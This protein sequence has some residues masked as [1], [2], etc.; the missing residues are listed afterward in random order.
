MKR[1]HVLPFGAEPVARGVRFRL[2]APSATTV[3]CAI[4]GSAPDALPM[5]PESGGWFALT[6]D[7]ARA[8]S[9]YRYLVDGMAVPDPA[10]RCQP[11]DV[12]GV[13]EVIDPE[14]YEWHDEAW[15]GRD[16]EEIVLYELH[17]GSFTATGDF[18]GVMRRLDHLVRL[19]V[20]AIE[21]MPVADFPGRRNWGY[22]GVL[23][24]APESRYGRPEDLKRLIEACHERGL[25]ILLDVV[26][27]HFGPD[28]NYLHAYA[29]DFFTKRHVTPWGDAINFDGPASRPVR[30][31]YIHNALY[32]LEEF[33]FDGLRFDAV[34]A[35]HDDSAPDILTEIAQTIR[36]RFTGSRPTHLI[37]ENDDN[38]PRYL[39]RDGAEPRLYTAQWDDDIH[40]ALHVL[41]TGET[42][43]YYEDYAECPADK[44]GRA[45]AEGFAYQGEA[46]AH[47]GGKKRG[48]PSAQLPPTAFISFLQNHDQVGNDAFG[49]RIIRQASPDAVHAAAAISLLSPH[50]P[51][52]FMGEEWGADQTFCF[53]C[54]FTGDLA[55]AVR[56]GRRREFAKSAG[57]KDPA[58]RERIPD[59][60]ADATFASSILDWSALDDPAHA[61]WLERYR[62]LIALR[63]REIAPRLRRIGGHAGRWRVIEEGALHVIWRL[64]DG[65]L[66]TLVAN[67]CERAVVVPETSAA[68]RRLYATAAQV[69]P[70]TAPPRSATFFLVTPEP[71]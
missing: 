46:S 55:V 60:Q 44:L 66:L 38:K 21:L 65:S 25:A 49:T 34:H 27:N 59:P 45:L 23:L 37:L 2:W 14:A 11:N 36:A 53:F 32:W 19:G 28:G 4:E 58:A 13:S 56:D 15:R 26:Y 1:H 61:A 33:H 35:I 50:I 29:G 52:L 8:G 16:W 20:T 40:H 24:F 6:T 48:A 68:G 47:R 7:A 17:T 30:D 54:D 3:Q 57:F 67:F 9:R 22:D 39:E 41:A 5:I 63:A 69:T 43:G 31:F 64:G 51:M 12:H 10:A 42:S 18:A 70:D 71:E 62:R